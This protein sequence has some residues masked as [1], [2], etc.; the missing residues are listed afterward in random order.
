MSLLLS[1]RSAPSE[2]GLVE[3]KV[4][5][6]IIRAYVTGI[7]VGV[8][9]AAYLTLRNR[10]RKI[11]PASYEATPGVQSALGAPPMVSRS[12]SSAVR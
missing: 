5:P 8:P 7:A 2:G 3:K 9:H 6:F 10:L 4:D 11:R 1:G 12:T